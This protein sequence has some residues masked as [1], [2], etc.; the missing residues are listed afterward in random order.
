MARAGRCA[1]VDASW[2]GGVQ[3]TLREERGP[4]ATFQG[5]GDWYQRKAAAL[6][7][8]RAARTELRALER[9]RK[10]RCLV[11]TRAAAAVIKAE[12]RR[13][14][15][16]VHLRAFAEYVYGFGI[17][18]LAEDDHLSAATITSRVRNGWKLVKAANLKR[19][20]DH[21]VKSIVGLRGSRR[22]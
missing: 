17:E 21:D 12:H 9:E 14:W 13:R 22:A 4:A 16:L 6:A 10:H 7:R 19:W 2:V 3:A 5:T 18:A 1:L 15:R 20:Q 8:F 11:E